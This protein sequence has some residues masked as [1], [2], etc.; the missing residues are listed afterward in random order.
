M[1]QDT[2]PL[3]PLKQSDLTGLFQQ[4]EDAIKDA[5]VNHTELIVPAVNEL[6]YAGY[7]ITNFLNDPSRTEEIRLAESHCKRATYDAYEA[8]ILFFVSEFKK[9]KDD[10]RNVTVGQIVPKFN[11]YNAFVNETIFFIKKIDKET[12]VEHYKKCQ[13]SNEKLSK[14][15]IEL[16]NAREELNKLIVK[17][18]RSSMIAICAV[19]TLLVGIL[20]LCR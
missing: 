14:I 12:K 17:E 16:D 4:A 5:E 15:I 13:A 9:F 20:A 10:Y 8:S 7:H 19:L 11:E 18:R 6:R 1:D 2:A 3:L